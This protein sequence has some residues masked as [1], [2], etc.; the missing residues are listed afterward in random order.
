MEAGCELDRL[1]AEQVFGYTVWDEEEECSQFAEGARWVPG[2]EYYVIDV[3]FAG[4]SEPPEAADSAEPLLPY[5][6]YIGAA[7]LIVEEL[8]KRGGILDLSKNWANVW[9]AA[10]ILPLPADDERRK[11]GYGSWSYAAT[12][13]TAQLAICR[14]ALLAAQATKGGA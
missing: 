4:P 3:P 1:V 10:F 11:D 9:R 5:S 2:S 6:E 13:D 8:E 14:A 7:W 12:A